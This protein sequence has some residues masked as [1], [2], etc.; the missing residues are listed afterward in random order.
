[1]RANS[2]IEAKKTFFL[3]LFQYN[4]SLN[5]IQFGSNRFPNGFAFHLSRADEE[6]FYL[7]YDMNPYSL[8]NTLRFCRKPDPQQAIQTAASC[9]TKSCT[10]NCLNITMEKQIFDERFGFYSCSPR[11]S[12]VGI[13]YTQSFPVNGDFVR[14]NLPMD[15]AVF[16]RRNSTDS[17]SLS[18]Q[19]LS[20]DTSSSCYE[21]INFDRTSPSNDI[22][23]LT[24]NVMNA[25]NRTMN[26]IRLIERS[27]GLVTVALRERRMSGHHMR[28]VD[29][30]IS[31]SRFMKN[32]LEILFDLIR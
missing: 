1:M 3:L 32:N 17:L 28:F 27:N 7:L 21:Y 4:S 26:G 11:T 13:V 14:P 10:S 9:D 25:N 20:N 8:L 16:V 2:F 12:L 6:S 15:Y 18:F 29:Y 23:S 31:K 19:Q 30:Q 5:Y 24:C 22:I